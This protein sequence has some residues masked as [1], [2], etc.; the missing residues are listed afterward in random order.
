[1]QSPDSETVMVELD[2]VYK[3]ETW[4]EM[5]VNKVIDNT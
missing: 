3:K 1:M 4:V 2:M 5:Q